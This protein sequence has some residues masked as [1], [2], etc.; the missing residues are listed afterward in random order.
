LMIVLVTG[1]ALVTP[2]SDSAE[3]KGT[4]NIT[5]QGGRLGNVTLGHHKHQNALG[6]CNVCHSQ[7]S[8]A[9]GSVEKLKGQGYLR[10]QEVMKN[11]QACHRARATKGEKAGP[12]ACSGC[13]KK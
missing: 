12:T 4:E 10:N 3:N 13:H 9:S 7:F 1:L 5:L 6:D 2:V 11:C 8:Q